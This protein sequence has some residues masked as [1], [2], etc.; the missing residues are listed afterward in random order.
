MVDIRR[1]VVVHVVAGSS[2]ARV[3][4]MTFENDSHMKVHG[5]LTLQATS[6][7]RGLEPP[8]AEPNRFL[9]HLLNHSDTVFLAVARRVGE[10]SI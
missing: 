8:R 6:T 10:T 4:S 9:V 2:P 5:G 7:P 3:I 1:W